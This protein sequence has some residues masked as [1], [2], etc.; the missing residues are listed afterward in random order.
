[1][2]CLLRTAVALLAAI[3]AS[4]AWAELHT[5]V[6]STDKGELTVFKMTV[7]PAAEPVPALKERLIAREIDTKEGN[8][9][10]FYYRAIMMLPDLS[11]A[12]REA[13]GEDAS[14]LISDWITTDAD[15]LP[16]D[17]VRRAVEFISGSTVLGQLR[18]GT[19]RRECDWG[20]RLDAIRGPDLYGFLLPEI[21]NSRELSRLLALRARQAI[22]D[23]R[24]EDAL[25]DL[26]INLK[27][28]RD[29]ASEPLLVCGLVGLA[30]AGV[31]QRVLIDMIA[32]PDSPNLYWAL[33][34][35]PDPL[36]NLREATRFEMNSGFRVFPFML[37]AENQEHSAEE[38]G[39]LLASGL[40]NLDPLTG[41]GPHLNE[42]GARLG[43]TALALA[44]YTPAKQRLIAGGM[45]AE[46]VEQMPVGQVIAVDAAREHRRIADELEKAWYVPFRDS[47]KMSDF[48]SLG[49]T[50]MDRGYGGLIASLLLPAVNAARSAEVRFQW[51][52]G[53]LRTVE[54]V[55]MHA[56]A[57]G[58]LPNSLDEVTEV[59]LPENPATGKRYDYRLD[60]D[61]AVLELPFSDNFSRVAWRFEIRLAK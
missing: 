56:A 19:A 20:W 33:T 11:K 47:L 13:V 40:M 57:T 44:T 12:L 5:E 38:W 36:V 23:G 43:V 46:R 50:K 34:E 14:E 3:V 52:T 54:A 61:A 49:T 37:D 2:N 6:Q 58:K 28:G 42:T 7:T 4:P 53:A 59:P 45:D 24:Y 21:Q 25:D 30:E 8:A 60:G 48:P 15:K 18:E 55:R 16:M 1:M 9:A 27:L 26:R 10:P 31:G 35:L 17:K 29:V 41:S 39:R 51:Q 22:I 32:A